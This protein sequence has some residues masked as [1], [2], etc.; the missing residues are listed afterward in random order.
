[1]VSGDRENIQTVTHLS[2][3]DVYKKFKAK[4]MFVAKTYR[5]FSVVAPDIKL[6]QT[7]QHSKNGAGGIIGL[8]RQSAFVS[9]LELVYDKILALSSSF[10][11]ITKPG[12]LKK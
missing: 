7:M 9:E 10:L 6:E 4:Y 11:E 1:M 8:T 12:K 2:H 5:S 3:P